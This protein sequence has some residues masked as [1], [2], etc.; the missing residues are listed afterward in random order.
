MFTDT[1]HVE[2]SYNVQELVR[3]LKVYLRTEDFTQSNA[4]V[5]SKISLV[6][7]NTVQNS[8]HYKATVVIYITVKKRS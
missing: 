7:I 3:T 5:C 8:S 2:L 6:V 1:K 4:N